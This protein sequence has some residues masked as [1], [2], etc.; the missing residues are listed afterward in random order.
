[1][2][3]T[4]GEITEPSSIGHILQLLLFFVSLLLNFERIQST[5]NILK[6]EFVMVPIH[7]GAQ[8]TNNCKDND[9]KTQQTPIR[10]NTTII[11]TINKTR[12]N[13]DLEIHLFY[14][15]VVTL[16]QVAFLYIV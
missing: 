5:V 8:L 10:A 7:I 6:F 3:K 1:M 14:G 15:S 13:K 4:T 9:Q 11:S 16:S 2:T 12:E